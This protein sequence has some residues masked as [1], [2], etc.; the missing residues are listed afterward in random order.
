MRVTRLI[1]LLAQASLAF[2]GAS[3]LST[4]AP[5]GVEEEEKH[6]DN[7]QNRPGSSGSLPNTSSFGKNPDTKTDQ[8]KVRNSIYRIIKCVND[9]TSGHSAARRRY[10]TIV[11]SNFI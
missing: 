7:T 2:S 5:L 3:E 8:E 6:Y 11:F 10:L 9:F 4:S 1:Y